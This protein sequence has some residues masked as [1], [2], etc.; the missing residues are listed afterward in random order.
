[1]DLTK[2]ALEDEEMDEAYEPRYILVLADIEQAF[3]VGKGAR[4]GN[5]QCGRGILGGKIA[6]YYHNDASCSIFQ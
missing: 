3:I 6:F 2:L 4:T 1:M 5:Q